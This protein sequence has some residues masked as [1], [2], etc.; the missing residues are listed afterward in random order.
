DVRSRSTAAASHCVR[1][2]LELGIWSFFGIWN[3]GFGAFRL[4]WSFSGAW[5]LE[6]GPFPLGRSFFGIW[7]L[8]FGAFPLNWSFSGAW[9]LEFGAFPLGRIFLPAWDF[10]EP[11]SRPHQLLESASDC[12]TKS[13]PLHS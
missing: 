3:L 6:L 13:S 9:C 4:V 5:C 10:V 12:F 8:G 11:S 1:R 7:N 2:H